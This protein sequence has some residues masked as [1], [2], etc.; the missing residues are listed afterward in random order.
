MTLQIPHGSRCLS[1]GG[2]DVSERGREMGMKKGRE[3]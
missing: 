2:R 1:E 3:V